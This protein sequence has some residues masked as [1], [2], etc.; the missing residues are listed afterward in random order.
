M[1]SLS[2]KIIKH[3]A[4]TVDQTN[5]TTI[6]N[7]NPDLWDRVPVNIDFVERDDDMADEEWELAQMRAQARES[8]MSAADKAGDILEEARRD[9]RRIVQEAKDAMEAER[10]EALKTARDEGYKAGYDEAYAIGAQNAEELMDEAEALLDQTTRERER[11][12]AEFEPKAVNLIIQIIDKLAIATLRTNPAA[13]LNLVKQGLAEARFAGDVVLRVAKDDFELVVEHKDEIMRHV[14][15]GAGLEIIADHSLNAA[16]CLIETPFGV[17][18]SS[19]R[20]Q[21]EE[22]KQDLA[23]ILSLS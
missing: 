16:D 6:S 18:D 20:L 7:E 19:L 10:E 5:K 8:M 14:T 23:Q 17:V 15:G 21:L 1:G 2:K 9:A 3:H 4:I 13:V 11:A 22:I 12:I